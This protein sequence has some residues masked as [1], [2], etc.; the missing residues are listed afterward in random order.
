VNKQCKL[1]IRS[2]RVLDEATATRRRLEQALDEAEKKAH[3]NLAL[4]KFMNFGYWAAIWTHLN[5]VGNFHRPNPFSDYVKLA[6]KKGGELDAKTKLV[7][8]AEEVSGSTE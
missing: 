7:A 6:R 8:K 5:R 4:Y 1:N 2:P 3:K